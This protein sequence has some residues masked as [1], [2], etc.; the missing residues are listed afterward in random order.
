MVSLSMCP[1]E[2][3]ISSGLTSG[4]VEDHFRSGNEFT[5]D[6]LNA[7]FYVSYFE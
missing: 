1:D 4:G 3:V 7:S 5:V 6:K 2:R